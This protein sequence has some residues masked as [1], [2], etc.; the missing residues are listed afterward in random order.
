MGKAIDISIV[1]EG[2]KKN[3]PVPQRKEGEKHRKVE[4]N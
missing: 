1:P 2:G 3:Q 4:S